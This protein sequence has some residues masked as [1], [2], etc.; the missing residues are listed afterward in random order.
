MVPR[1]E[2]V[3]LVVCFLCACTAD[4][5][6]T[7]K[8]T[9]SSTVVTPGSAAAVATPTP[10]APAHRDTA[11]PASYV[12]TTPWEDTKE[13]IDTSV[14]APSFQC[15]P[16]S[17]TPNDTV[18]LWM[19]VPHG[20]AL[21]VERPDGFSFKLVTPRVEGVANYSIVPSEAFANMAMIRFR[22]D[23]RSE[24]FVAG[25]DTVE[26]IFAQPGKYVFRVG[27]NLNSDVGRDV[28]DC[29]IRLVPVRN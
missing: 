8:S 4:T 29:T 18:T 24:P 6:E 23:I 15:V 25:H 5:T 11:I 19:V 13:V 26:T 22:G 28:R 9:D 16:R 12:V 17:F 20:D 1:I 2:K 14:S 10:A 21:S 3:A 7:S 27:S